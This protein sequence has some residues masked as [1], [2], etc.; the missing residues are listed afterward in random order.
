MTP[1]AEQ[2]DQSDSRHIQRLDETRRSVTAT[3]EAEQRALTPADTM[4]AL[5]LQVIGG[6]ESVTTDITW[7][8][9]HLAGF[10]ADELEEDSKLARIMRVAADEIGVRWP[11]Q[12]FASAITFANN[13]RRTLAHLLYIESIVGERPHR[14]MRIVRPGAPGEPRQRTRGLSWRD[15]T[16]SMQTRHRADILEQDLIAALAAIRSVRDCL[17]GLNRIRGIL[18][19]EGTREGLADDKIIDPFM[20]Q[21]NW[22]LPE[23]GELWSRPLTVADVFLQPGE[24]NPA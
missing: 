16:W 15:E 23:W 11:H 1:P 3:R 2:P 8:R 22:W 12:P 18:S 10:D 19:E 6:W 7:I 4:E 21:V 9:F 5:A 14:T 13:T 20:W 17:H 24:T